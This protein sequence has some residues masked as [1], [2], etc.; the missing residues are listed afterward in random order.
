MK[1]LK[2]QSDKTVLVTGSAGFIGF[3]LSL[4]LLKRGLSVIGVDNVNDYYDIGIKKDR[5]SILSDYEQY[6]HEYIDIS[7]Y[8]PLQDCFRTYS[9]QLVVNLAAQ[10]GV[11]YSMENPKA[12]LDSNLIGFFNI[13]ET[14]KTFKIEHLVYASSSSVYGSNEKL[15]FS[16]EDSVDHPLSLYAATKRS[17]ELLAHSYSNLYS[18]PTTGLRF[19]TV[20]GP[21]GRPDMALFKFTEAILKNQPI[22]LF[23]KGNHSRDFTYIDDI[24][25]GIIRV[26]FSTPMKNTIPLEKT[27]LNSMKS[28]SAA[29]WCVYNIGSGRKIELEYFITLIEGKL[30]K[31]AKFKL[32]PMQ[33][34]DVSETLSDVNDLKQE[35]GYLPQTGVEEGVSKFVDW[36]LEYYKIGK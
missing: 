4:S 19:F 1:V 33:P 6:T 27:E 35:L 34:G 11:R 14:C 16:T 12:Y 13:L 36:Y 8:H 31:K 7:E 2:I 26:L 22:T 30:N 25:D 21:W 32:L 24:I 17:N 3:H 20:Y 5:I 10:A 18:L 29:P 23:N 15:P 28:K 9:P